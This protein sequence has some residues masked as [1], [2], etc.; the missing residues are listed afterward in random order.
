MQ[1][2]LRFSPEESR[3]FLSVADYAD[4][5]ADGARAFAERMKK[6][7]FDEIMAARQPQSSVKSDE[8]GG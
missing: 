4:G 2:G 5:F 8:S 7:K 3:E 1:T 6:R